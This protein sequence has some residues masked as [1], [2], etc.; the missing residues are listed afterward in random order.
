MILF[1]IRQQQ[2][3]NRE[4][5]PI[6]KIMAFWIVHS[7]ANSFHPIKITAFHSISVHLIV[8]KDINISYKHIK[9]LIEFKMHEINAKETNNLSLYNYKINCHSLQQTNQYKCIRFWHSEHHL[10]SQFNL[11][12]PIFIDWQLKTIS[13]Q[14]YTVTQIGVIHNHQC[15]CSSFHLAISVSA[16]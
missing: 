12:I 16:S 3:V 4:M 8:H 7:L 9:K 15:W 2:V 6:E 11:V 10:C 13:K 1:Y 5:K 14:I